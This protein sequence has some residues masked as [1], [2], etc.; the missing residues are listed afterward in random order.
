MAEAHDWASEV[1]A[2]LTAAGWRPDRQID[3]RDWARQLADGSGFH[4][5]AAAAR[6]LGEFGGL[7]VPQRRDRGQ[8]VASVTFELDPRNGA[9]RRDWF[10]ALGCPA[11]GVLYPIGDAG[12]GHAILAIDEDSTVFMLFGTE[13]RRIGTGPEAVANLVTGRRP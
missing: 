11:H 10:R 8:D 12:G 13:C 7:N 6:F 2:H 4:L 3:L 5:H 1:V 9:G